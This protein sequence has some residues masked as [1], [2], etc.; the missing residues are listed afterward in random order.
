MGRELCWCPVIQHW[1]G[2]CLDWPIKSFLCWCLRTWPLKQKCQEESSIFL[3]NHLFPRR[4]GFSESPPWGPDSRKNG[5]FWDEILWSPVYSHHTRLVPLPGTSLPI[6]KLM[7]S[8]SLKKWAYS[9]LKIIKI[10]KNHTTINNFWKN[11]DTHLLTLSSMVSTWKS[12]STLNLAHTSC[13]APPNTPSQEC[14]F[15]SS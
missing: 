8:Y 7:C 10:G 1:P 14:S 13:C 6:H 3:L 2:S 12:L 15:P 9:Y 4:A 5:I 11:F